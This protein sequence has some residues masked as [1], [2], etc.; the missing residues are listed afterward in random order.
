M[1]SY[2]RQ[3]YRQCRLPTITRHAAN[4]VMEVLWLKRKVRKYQAAV[5]LIPDEGWGL[6]SSA[7][8]LSHPKETGFSIA[9]TAELYLIFAPVRLH[10]H[11]NQ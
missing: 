8:A 11:V 5:T 7:I 6:A 2:Q 4:V 10:T 9:E 3:S 1:D